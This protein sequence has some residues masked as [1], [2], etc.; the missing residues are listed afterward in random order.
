[1]KLRFFFY[2]IAFFF[3]HI[4]CHKTPTE[5][6]DS[7]SCKVNGQLWT[8][9]GIVNPLG[10]QPLIWV[11]QNYYMDSIVIN[12]ERDIR[13]KSGNYSLSYEWFNL[14]KIGL[15]VNSF[16]EIKYDQAYHKDGCGAYMTDTTKSNFIKTTALDT[17]N[18]IVKGTFQLEC[19]GSY[20]HDNV[21]ITEGQFEVKY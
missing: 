16:T 9:A 4:S 10:G 12:T 6:Q 2:L 15:K 13:D 11:Y 19:N 17:V 7:F 18:R 21:K 5:F 3:L 14:Y 20:C 1:M 8:P